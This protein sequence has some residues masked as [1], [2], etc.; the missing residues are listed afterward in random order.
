M[1]LS[2]IRIHVPLIAACEQGFDAIAKYLIDHG[3]DVNKKGKYKEYS[4]PLLSA[5]KANNEEIA[6]YLIDH[7]ADVNLKLGFE[8][9]VSSFQI[10][11]DENHLVIPSDSVLINHQVY[12]NP[13]KY[14]CENGNES[15]VKY[16]VEHGA[17]DFDNSGSLLSACE[18]G[19]EAIIKYLVEC[20]ADV[21]Q[22]DR[23]N[24]TPLITVCQNENEDMVRYLIEHGADKLINHKD[25][26]GHSPLKI[27][28]ENKNDSI[29][30]YLIEH[31]ADSTNEN[32]DSKITIN[33]MNLNFDF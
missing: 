24:C 19:N 23:F 20:G 16:L 29:V 12:H 1:G 7:G 30:N 32:D 4:A 21:N 13:L 10:V 5:C 9:N 31:G 28:R 3:A 25:K 2:L 27:A 15:L 33:I 18:N 14:A 26:F 17:N 6:K 8:V 22:T 11:F